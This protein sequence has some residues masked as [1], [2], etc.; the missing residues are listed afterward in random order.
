MSK[1]TRALN[2]EEIKIIIDTIRNGFECD[3]K[4]HKPN[5]RIATIL[6]LQLNLG[7]RISDIMSLRLSSFIKEVNRMRL[8]VVEQKTGKQRNFTVPADVY[9]FILSYC[10]ENNIKKNAKIFDISV[11][12][13]QKHL[14]IAADYLN[15]EGVGSHSFRKAY[16]TRMYEESNFDVVLVKELMQHSDT[17]TTLKYIGISTEKVEKVINSSIVLL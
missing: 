11:R 3:G 12:A 10:Y 1:K 6:V 16:C 5:N 15:I 14:K 4:I 8:N 9:N 13:V 7:M 2:N 17:K